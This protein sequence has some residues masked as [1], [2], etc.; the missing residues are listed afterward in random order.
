MK[1]YDISQAVFGCEVYPGDPAPR[2]ELVSSI[3]GGELYNLTVFTMCAHNGT[4]VDAPSHF[5]GSGDTVSEMELSRVVGYA[6]VIAHEGKISGNDARDILAKAS[7]VCPEAAKRILIAGR[8]T[9]TLEAAQTFADSG[10]LLIG[11]ESQSVGP[12]D[13]PM[14]VHTTLLSREIALL[15]GIR[16]GGIPEG[17]YLLSAAPLLLNGCDGAPCRAVLISLE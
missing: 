15:E 17:K 3:D 2:K 9:V 5:F 11:N 7:A 16:L 8:A 4:H 1:I 14:A 10:I 13:A 6:Y 12:E